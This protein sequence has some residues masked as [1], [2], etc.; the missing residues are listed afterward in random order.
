MNDDKAN[1]QTDDPA[2][3]IAD[4]QLEDEETTGSMPNPE[5]VGNTA[6]IATG[7]GIHAKDYDDKP[8]ELHIAQDLMN[9][10][11]TTSPSEVDEEE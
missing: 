10:A 1:N 9:N 5:D 2:K 3:Y 11:N 4:E 8:D 6:E 7:F